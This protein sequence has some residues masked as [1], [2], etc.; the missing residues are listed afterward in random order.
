MKK[1]ILLLALAFILGTAFAQKDKKIEPPAPVKAKLTS[2]YP[3]V[4]DV[5]WTKEDV[6]YEASFK[7]KETETSLLFG[8]KGNFLEKEEAIPETLLPQAAKD[9]LAINYPSKKITE[10]AKITDDEGVVT[11]EAEIDKTDIIFDAD[12]KIINIGK[13]TGETE[14]NE[15]ND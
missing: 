1:L 2:L 12:G 9:Y 14:N 13:E 15:D 4:K 10:A 3:M 8:A 5:K 7:N 6:N 11:Y